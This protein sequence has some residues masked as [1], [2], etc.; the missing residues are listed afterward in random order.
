MLNTRQR[1]LG[2]QLSQPFSGLY[3]KIC[4]EISYIYLLR[5]QLRNILVFLRVSEMR[6]ACYAISHTLANKA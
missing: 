5:E 2:N 4:E 6:F 3:F 1:E